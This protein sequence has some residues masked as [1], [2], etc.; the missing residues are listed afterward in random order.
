MILISIGT[1]GMA[2]S[3]KSG[4]T[5]LVIVIVILLIVTVVV[6]RDWRA[7]GGWEE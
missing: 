6:C 4:D 1:V 2:N 7:V 5:N 3:R